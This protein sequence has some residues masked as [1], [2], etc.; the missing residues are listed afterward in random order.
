MTPTIAPFSDGSSSMTPLRAS[1][2]AAVI[3]P[4]SRAPGEESIGVSL[5]CKHFILFFLNSSS[6]SN[7]VFALLSESHG[8]SHRSVLGPLIIVDP[9]DSKV[10][11][12]PQVSVAG[13][14]YQVLCEV[15]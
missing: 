7:V 14:D 12:I 1:S 10:H 11:N 15:I 3:Q 6:H 9:S 2:V 4:A 8:F 13:A 5:A